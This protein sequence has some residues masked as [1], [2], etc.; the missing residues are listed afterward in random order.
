M[1]G[2]AR[3]A[4]SPAAA[5]KPARGAAPAPRASRG[6]QSIEV[7]GQLLVGLV[8]LGR[9]VPLKDLAQAA[10]MTPA[11][12]HPYLVSFCKLGL[13]QQD[14]GSGHYGLGP[15]A[16]QAGLISMQQVDPIRLAGAELPRLAEA[17]GH[18]VGLAIWGNRGPTFVRLAEGPSA[19]HVN[20]RHG[21]V[22]SVFGTAS[23]RLFAAFVAREDVLAALRAETG[24]ASARIEAGLADELA[25][26][27]KQGFAGLK[28][29][30]IPGISAI[31]A[32]VFDGFG[33]M[34]ASLTA[35]G[36]GATLDASIRGGAART[37]I[38][39]AARLSARLG[40]RPAA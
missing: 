30:T 31:A 14:A 20:M 24:R 5:A 16:L 28:D 13:I 15:L 22:V 36:P 34:V 40:A 37:L 3:A 19:V 39:T 12:A 29:G 8:H 27:R 26:I 7:G 21:T 1:S 4:A 11:K 25:R 17:I 38:D 18:T 33:T 9:P 32:P 35:I 6:I 10:G 23:G 2:S